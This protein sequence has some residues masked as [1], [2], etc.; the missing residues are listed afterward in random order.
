MKLAIPYRWMEKIQILQTQIGFFNMIYLKDNFWKFALL[1]C[2]I[3]CN[4]SNNLKTFNLNHQL[5]QAKLVDGLIDGK[6]TFYDSLGNFIN[7]TTYER[8]IRS[9]I[10]INYY[11][12]RT[13][14]D[15]VEIV[16]GKENG[17][18]RYYDSNG[19][20]TYCAYYYYGLLFGPELM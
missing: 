7:I 17:Y 6:A 19:N 3:S 9:G 5:V 13:V 4:N 10:S 11:A 8:G 12:N 18:W 15:S 20:R 1:I 16:A 2:E 14:S